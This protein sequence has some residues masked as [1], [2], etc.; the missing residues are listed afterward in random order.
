MISVKVKAGLFVCLFV[1][2]KTQVAQEE[3]SAERILKKKN[4][5]M[6]NRRRAAGEDEATLPREICEA[7]SC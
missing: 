6:G 7:A 2:G 5:H 4:G 1:L 3:V